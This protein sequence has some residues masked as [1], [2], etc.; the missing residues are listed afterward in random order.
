MSGTE[1]LINSVIMARALL[2]LSVKLR[3]LSNQIDRAHAEGRTLSNDELKPIADDAY[4]S[5]DQAILLFSQ[6]KTETQND[7]TG[8]KPTN[9]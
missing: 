1:I 8:Q 6:P 9:G 5:L 2:E 4:S 3:E 7:D